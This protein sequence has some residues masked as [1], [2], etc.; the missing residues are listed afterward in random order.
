MLPTDI[1]PI[2]SPKCEFDLCDDTVVKGR[3]C[4]KHFNIAKA[5]LKADQAQDNLKI[6]EKIYTHVTVKSVKGCHI[7]QGQPNE[8]GYGRSTVNGV[9][10]YVH[11]IVYERTRGVVDFGK[12][13]HHKCGNRLCVN[14]EHIEVVSHLEHGKK[15]LSWR[16]K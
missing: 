13:L 2:A 9:R 6:L 4:K 3:Y 1:Q 11:R 5:Q 12:M 16:G 15:H 14:P 10:M 7:W 8:K